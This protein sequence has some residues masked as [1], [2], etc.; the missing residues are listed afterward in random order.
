MD[1][2][3]GDCEYHDF[4]IDHHFNYQHLEDD[5]DIDHHFSYQ[6]LEDVPGISA[7]KPSNIVKRIW[8]T[9]LR[10]DV[11]GNSLKELRMSE[12]SFKECPSNNEINFYEKYLRIKNYVS[13][14]RT[15]S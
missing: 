13:K 11:L 3:Q 7:I 15:N 12:T 9:S 1:F 14:K 2:D 5:C 4:R 8:K 10:F 6:L